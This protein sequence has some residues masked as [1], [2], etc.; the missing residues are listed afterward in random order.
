[1]PAHKAVDREVGPAT[2]ASILGNSYQRFQ[3]EQ[4]QR[5]QQLTREDNEFGVI[6]LPDSRQIAYA[7]RLVTESS[8]GA[9]A[10]SDNEGK[11]GK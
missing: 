11:R 6:H 10:S 4:R 2:A 9:W 3:E 8:R 5:D 1:M 7:H